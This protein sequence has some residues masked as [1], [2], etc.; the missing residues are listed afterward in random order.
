MKP[1]FKKITLF[2]ILFLLVP[3]F[4]VYAGPTFPTDGS[5]TMVHLWNGIRNLANWIFA[6]LALASLIGVIIGGFIFVTS[7]GD[8]GKVSSAKQIIIYSLVGVLIGSLALVL[9]NWVAGITLT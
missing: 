8:S 1:Y 3:V 7:S 9:I 4:F 6:F 5:R 2:F